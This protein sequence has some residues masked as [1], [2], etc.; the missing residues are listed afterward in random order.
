[1]TTTH[2]TTV[3]LDRQMISLSGGDL[4]YADYGSGP[5][6]LFLH[7]VLVNADLWRNVLPALADQR[8]CIA[9]D[10]PAHGASPCP[11]QADL[12]LAGLASLVEELCA[13]LDLGQVDLVANDTGGAVAQVFAGLHPERIRT[14]T[15]TNC[16][17]HENFPPE[18]FRPTI[19]LAERGEFGPLVVA[20]A[21]D[22]AVAR[23]ELGYGQAYQHPEALTDGLLQ[24]YSAPFVV[25]GGQGL[26]RFMT[27]S[28]ASQLMA[29]APLLAQLDAPTQLVWG[30]GDPFFETFWTE[31]LQAMIPGVERITDLPDAMLFFP[32]ERADEFIPLLRSFWELHP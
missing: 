25:D 7:G 15:L 5:S 26:E 11:P 18:M 12:S 8:R 9:V 32:D 27:S 1:M 6:A 3:K 20:M 30:T 22:L 13:A 10:L 21:G 31:R 28:N 17:V 2:D 19:E 14:L 29:V 4:A 16:D 24:S 23:S